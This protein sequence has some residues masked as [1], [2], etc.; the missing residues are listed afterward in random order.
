[1][2][3]A[4]SRSD[5]IKSL[6]QRLLTSQQTPGTGPFVSSGLPQLDRLLPH[7]SLRC[8]S[9]IE[10]VSSVPGLSATVLALQC[11]RQ[12]LLHPGAL[13]VIDSDHDF[14]SAAAAAVGI[15]LDRLLLIRP[16]AT[17]HQTTRTIRSDHLWSLEQASRCPGVR[18]VLCRLDR[19]SSTVLRRLQLAVEASGVTVFL[20]R[21]ASCLALTSWADIRLLLDSESGMNHPAHHLTVRVT[22]SRHAVEHHGMVCLRINHETGVVSEVSELADPATADFGTC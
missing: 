6:R 3:Q 21:P 4:S 17:E 22:H 16:Q 19:A 10:C 12:L 9:V 5:V 7:G 11:I 1:M 18:A 20:V 15:P 8:G 14:N 2:S 13:V